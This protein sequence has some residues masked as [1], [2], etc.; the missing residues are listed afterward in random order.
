MYPRSIRE[1]PTSP[2]WHA[3]Q[4]WLPRNWS[5]TLLCNGPCHGGVSHAPLS[6]DSSNKNEKSSSPVQ[7]PRSVSF[8]LGAGRAVISVLGTRSVFLVSFLLRRI[9]RAMRRKSQMFVLPNDS[10]C[11]SRRFLVSASPIMIMLYE[12]VCGYSSSVYCFHASH[13]CSR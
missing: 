6:G 9:S 7:R 1:C 8:S 3:R 5:S 12:A 10:L 13:S 11:C 4:R 2:E